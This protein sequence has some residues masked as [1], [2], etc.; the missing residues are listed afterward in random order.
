MIA[1]PAD[2]AATAAPMPVQI[3]TN[4]PW[5]RC[6]AKRERLIGNIVASMKTVSEQIQ[7]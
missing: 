1:K 3:H 6:P 7:K 4:W 5:P 2:G